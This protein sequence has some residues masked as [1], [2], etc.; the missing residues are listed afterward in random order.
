MGYR[1]E[2]VG[3]RQLISLPQK[4]RELYRAKHT[5]LPSK[6]KSRFCW[7]SGQ[8]LSKQITLKYVFTKRLSAICACYIDHPNKHCKSP[9]ASP[10]SSTRLCHRNLKWE[11]APKISTKP[12]KFI[13]R[14]AAY[15]S[16]LLYPET[17]LFEVPEGKFLT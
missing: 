1:L 14:K 12:K 8:H 11:F 6:S 5:V 3:K 15:L 17:Q 13:P 9:S 4:A 7:H 10:Q 2:L 16:V